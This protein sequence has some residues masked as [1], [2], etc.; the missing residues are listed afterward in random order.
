M[1]FIDLITGAG[2][3]V[4]NSTTSCPPGAD[5]TDGI[6]DNGGQQTPSLPDLPSGTSP[7][8]DERNHPTNAGIPP[9]LHTPPDTFN[10]LTGLQPTGPNGPPGMRLGGGVQGMQQPHHGIRP[11][12]NG[13]KSSLGSNIMNKP[14]GPPPTG[15]GVNH[16][17]PGNGNGNNTGGN[18]QG[19]NMEVQYMQQQSQI[20]VFSTMLANKSA[21]AVSQGHFQSI[22]AYHCAQPGTKKYFEKHPL[23]LTQFNRQS[24]AQWLNGLAMM[25]NKGCARGGMGAPQQIPPNMIGGGGKPPP[26]PPSDQ[27]VPTGPMGLVDPYPVHD[28]IVDD[29]ASTLQESDV[30]WEQQVIN[31]KYAHNSF[32]IDVLIYSEVVHIQMQFHHQQEEQNYQ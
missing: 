15:V 26:P 31:R 23:K 29:I 10:E 13:I 19:T 30:P 17:T 11:P 9:D 2:T 8:D 6:I 25:K 1:N 16:P 28:G 3:G 21:E 24:P 14:T 18:G 22:I 12:T 27:P 7:Q 32:L 4:T 20:F 5:G